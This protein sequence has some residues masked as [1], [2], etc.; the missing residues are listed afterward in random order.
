M[1]IKE[2]L[3]KVI[4]PR[5]RISI[6]EGFA[7]FLCVYIPLFLLLYK[8]GTVS[9][10]VLIIY[11]LFVAFI[12]LA[13]LLTFIYD[14]RDFLNNEKGQ[15][16][17]IVTSYLFNL[18]PILITFKFI[19]YVFVK[20]PINLVNTSLCEVVCFVNDLSFLY[21]G[22]R[23]LDSIIIISFLGTLLFAFIYKLKKL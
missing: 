13:M 14:L 16:G 15:V 3:S 20:L 9:K 23:T 22:Q 5:G 12:S 2:N 10:V 1:K 19:L 6:R 21:R 4:M 8:G 7:I 11:T 18:L 17:N